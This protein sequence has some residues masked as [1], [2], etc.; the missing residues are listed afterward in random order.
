MA[1][2]TQPT[3]ANDGGDESWVVNFVNFCIGNAVEPTYNM[4]VS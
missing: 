4:Y 2:K 1:Q 3:L